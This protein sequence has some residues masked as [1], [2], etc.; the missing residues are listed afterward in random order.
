MGERTSHAPGTF[1]WVDLS[2]SDPD[3]AKTFY[4]A[5]FGWDYD[6]REV[7]GGVYSMALKDGKEAGA[8]S[9]AQPGQP[10]AWNS[11]VTVESADAAAAAAQEQG[12][13]VMGEPFDVMD[14][15]RMATVFDPN[16]SA[17]AVWE[18]RESVGAAVVN[19][20]GTLTMNQ[21]NTTAPE[22][23]QD[24]YS[25]VFGWRFESLPDAD[26][27]YWGIYN[28]D[29]LNAGMLQQPPD[30]WLAYFG[31]ESVDDDAGRIG[32]LGGEM[33]V[34]PLSIPAGRLLV[35]RD[36]QGAVFALFSGDFDD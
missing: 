8:I 3:G 10:T 16:G 6:D 14:A 19:E 30:M 4:A 18:P 24:F 32:E 12:G 1:S 36:P 20:P 7:P 21:L 11:Y 35:A 25:G 15:G 26:Q 2:T 33:M 23:S 29:R 5:L 31:S 28:G 9:G 22:R 34:P 17:F 13:E 27:P